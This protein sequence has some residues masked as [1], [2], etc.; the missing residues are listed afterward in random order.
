MFSHFFSRFRVIISGVGLEICNFDQ[1]SPLCYAA[2]CCRRQSMLQVS[3][4][5]IDLYHA[6][7]RILN[8]NTGH[9]LILYASQT[10]SAVLLRND[11]ITFRRV[12][13]TEI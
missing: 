2:V 8:R 11:S 6:F 7:L 13:S 10:Q 3:I 9:V 5:V 4:P 12:N 1:I